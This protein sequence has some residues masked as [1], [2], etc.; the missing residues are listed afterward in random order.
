MKKKFLAGVLGM[1]AVI[2]MVVTYTHGE[3]WSQQAEHGKTFVE[4][5]H[6]ETW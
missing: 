5:T 1:M 6:G 4:M 3:T 2:G